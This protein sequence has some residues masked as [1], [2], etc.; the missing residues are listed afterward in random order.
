[1]EQLDQ[2]IEAL[3]IKL[4]DAECTVLEERYQPQPVRG[5]E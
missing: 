5:H 1:M 4:D 3:D 2:A